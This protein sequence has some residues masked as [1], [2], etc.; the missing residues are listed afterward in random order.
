[1]YASWNKI[2][3]ALA[4]TTDNAFIGAFN[5]TLRRG[6]FSQQ[7]FLSITDAQATLICSTS[8]SIE[9]YLRLVCFSL[10]ETS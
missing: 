2:D 9:V 7:R 8:P 1:M 3:E 4:D 5:G 6:C 10:Y